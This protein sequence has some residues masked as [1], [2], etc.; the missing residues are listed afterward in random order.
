MKRHATLAAFLVTIA[1]AVP[2]AWHALGADIEHD[3][4]HLR[5]LQKT[6]V[7]D[8]GVKVTLDV[9]RSVVM[10]GDTVTATLRAFADKRQDVAIDVHALHSTNYEGERVSQPWQQI[11]RETIQ[12]VAA[13]NGGKPVTTQIKLADLPEKKALA[14][15]FEIMI[16][17]H[18]Q[19]FTTNKFDN[20]QTRTDY[21]SV[22]E[23][24]AAAISIEGW[25]GNSLAMSI[26]RQGKV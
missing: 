13:P 5:P 21:D 6:L 16:T 9:D 14:D 12:L 15:S 3:G 24:K 17:A 11:D 19:K 8:N 23:G 2:A 26:E 20:G 18:G 4:K 1:V 10:T 22:E 25:S 7:L